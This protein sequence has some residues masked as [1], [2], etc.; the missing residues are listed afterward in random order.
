MRK[1]LATWKGT[2]LLLALVLTAARAQTTRPVRDDVGFS[3]R[4]GDMDSL[5]AYLARNA[6]GEPE[7]GGGLLIGGI[8]PHD[9][10]LYAGP[11]Y[12]PLF[13]HL[14]AREVV[15]IGLVHGAVR[16]E[17]SN[18]HDVLIFDAYE[19]WS[20]PYG[21]VLPSPLREFLKARL[22][23]SD[24]MVSNKAHDLEHSIEALI[25]FVQYGTRDVRITPIMVTAMDLPRMEE[26]GNR[27]ADLFA[28]YIAEKKLKL[29]EDIAFLIST[30]ANHYGADFNNTPFGDDEAAHRKATENDRRIAATYLNGEITGERTRRLSDEIRWDSTGQSGRPLWC[31]RYP[32]AFGL[33]TIAKTVSLLHAGSVRGALLNYSDSWTGGVLPLRGTH[34]GLTA[35]FSLK[36]WVGF[37]SAGLYLEKPN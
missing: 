21:P 28:S 12:Y 11:I 26:L 16:R 14:R 35:P 13:K 4:A 33:M 22:P 19:R 36:H 3:W 2:V 29:G 10:Y 1:F 7:A 8:S 5:M 31:G 25:P 15:I 27:L 34:L 9:D 17:M 23:K 18:P 6:G 32:V 30:D 37:F 24:V 20:G